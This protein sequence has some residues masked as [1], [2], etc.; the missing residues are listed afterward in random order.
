MQSGFIEVI[1]RKLNY[2]PSLEDAEDFLLSCVNGDMDKIATYANYVFPHDVCV[3]AVGIFIRYCENNDI[4]LDIVKDVIRR[5]DNIL[6]GLMQLK[7]LP[8]LLNK[9]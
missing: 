2:N 7:K 5:N 9:Y 4:A 6:F 8:L 3:D 1:H